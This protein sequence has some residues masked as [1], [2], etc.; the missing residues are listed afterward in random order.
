MSYTT[1]TQDTLFHDSV[2]KLTLNSLVLNVPFFA[3]YLNIADIATK[4]KTYTHLLLAHTYTLHTHTVTDGIGTN[5]H[6]HE[7]SRSYRI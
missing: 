1:K 3:T 6:T 5:Q 2:Q 7:V 4:R